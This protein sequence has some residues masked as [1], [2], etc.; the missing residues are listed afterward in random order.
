MLKLKKVIFNLFRIGS[1]EIIKKVAPIGKRIEKIKLNDIMLG[2]I[3]IIGQINI[4]IIR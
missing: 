3:S 4:I 1:N 2:K